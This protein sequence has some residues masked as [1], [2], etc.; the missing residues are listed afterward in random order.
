M[1]KTKDVKISETG[2]LSERLIARSTLLFAVIFVLK[3]M[4]R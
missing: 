2:L 1:Q 4:Q 3:N